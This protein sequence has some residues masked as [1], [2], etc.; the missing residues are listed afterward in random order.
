MMSLSELNVDI[1]SRMTLGGDVLKKSW[2]AL[3][4]SRSL[5]QWL[6]A[7]STVADRYFRNG[8][9]LAEA[10]D[11]SVVR[12]EDVNLDSMKFMVS[13][14]KDIAIDIPTVSRNMKQYMS[15][16]LT[17]NPQ[18]IKDGKYLFD[19][20]TMN[21][22]TAFMAIAGFQ[23]QEISEIYEIDKEI[24]DGRAAFALFGDADSDII[25]RVLS[26]HVLAEGLSVEHQALG[27]QM[28]NSILKKYGP[29]ESAE[30]MNAVWEKANSR[31]FDQNE[32]IIKFLMESEKRMQEGLDVFNTMVARKL[33]GLRE[34]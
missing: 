24:N 12:N 29:M 21:N 34:Q 13:V 23:P 28:V 26:T 5:W 7:S 33:K 17:Q 1:S 27:A 22:R 11:L 3:T 2:E 15:Y 6:G 16:F 18:F 8:Q 19:L 30:I 25:R 20:E 31:R 4:G 10:F 32:L 14:L 9:F